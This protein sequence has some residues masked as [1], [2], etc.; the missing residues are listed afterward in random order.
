MSINVMMQQW[1]KGVVAGDF[2]RL[3]HLPTQRSAVVEVVRT[4]DRMLVVNKFNRTAEPIR[5]MKRDGL[6]Y[7]APKIWFVERP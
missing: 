1:R 7:G 6:N 5:I 2:V 4:T 3:C